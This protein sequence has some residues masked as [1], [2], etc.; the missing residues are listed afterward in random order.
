MNNGRVIATLIALALAVPTGAALAEQQST[1]MQQQQG[2][3]GMQDGGLAAMNVGDLKGKQ[4]KNAEG[5]EIGEV[6]NVGIGPDKQAYA[7]VA[8]GGFWGMGERDVAIPLVD[9][10]TQDDE[11]VLASGKS[12]DQLKQEASARNVQDYQTL[13]DDQSLAQYVGGGATGSTQMSFQQMDTDSDGYI[14]SQEAAS[15]PGLAS[16]MQSADRN[17]DGRL[18]RSEFSAFEMQSE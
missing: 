10:Q 6:Q 7:I 2:T 8:V 14:S 1:T 18:D 16:Q 9:L 3:A 11:I 5:K 17:G 4:V 13:E 15:S 12:E